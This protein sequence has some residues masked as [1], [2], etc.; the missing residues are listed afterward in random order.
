MCI[1]VCSLLLVLSCVPVTLRYA[2]LQW[3]QYLFASP[4][5]TA[6]VMY[7]LHVICSSP[8]HRSLPVWNGS[9]RMWTP[10]HDAWI[11]DLQE[12][13]CGLVHS[14]LVLV[15]SV[16]SQWSGFGLG[17]EQKACHYLSKTDLIFKF[18]H[19]CVRHGMH[20][21]Y[22]LNVSELINTGTCTAVW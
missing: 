17:M 22:K 3:T 16:L 13:G 19:T 14:C 1:S 2:M 4:I 9:L 8:L 20:S 21:Y 6:L 5:W 12:L 15:I 10:Q 18:C 11:L 7:T